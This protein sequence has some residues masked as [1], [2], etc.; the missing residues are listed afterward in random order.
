MKRASN[1]KVT[2]FGVARIKK[3]T[4]TPAMSE[5]YGK[6]NLP[7]FKWWLLNDPLIN[8]VKKHLD[9]VD[10][11]LAG[12]SSVIGDFKT[13]LCEGD[14]NGW[15]QLDGRPLTDI[16]EKQVILN[17]MGITEKLPTKRSKMGNVFIYLG[18]QS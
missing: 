7:T 18:H 1:K 8:G 2:N 5:R 11:M 13:S 6:N 3:I 4:A 12:S 17:S 16:P 15:Y 14:H 9:H 10:K